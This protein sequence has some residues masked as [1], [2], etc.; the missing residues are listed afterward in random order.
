MEAFLA[1]SVAEFRF[2]SSIKHEKPPASGADQFATDSPIAHAAFIPMVN[3]RIRNSSR[4]IS[5][6]LP[7][8]VHQPAKLMQVTSLQRVFGS[9]A[10]FFHEMKILHHRRVLPPAAIVLVFQNLRSGPDK[11]GIE[12]QQ[13]IF[14]I[15]ES[16]LRNVERVGGYASV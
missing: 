9:I 6:A 8:T 12:K 5:L 4:A 15:E 14:Q 10:R 16:F 13:V 1:H 3:L 2:V 11:T 7:V